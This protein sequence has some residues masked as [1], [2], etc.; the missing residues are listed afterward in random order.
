MALNNAIQFRHSVAELTPSETNTLMTKLCN[1][2][3]DVVL[4][5]IFDYLTKPSR[6]ADAAYVEASISSIIEAR[7]DSFEPLEVDVLSNSCIDINL[8]KSPAHSERKEIHILCNDEAQLDRIPRSL[9][10]VVSS[11]LNQADYT[12]LAQTSRSVYL[13]CTSPITLRALDWMMAQ[14]NGLVS[15]MHF[16][17]FQHVEN[18]SISM[19]DPM[20]INSS[21]TR[22]RLWSRLRMIGLHDGD[23]DDDDD[24]YDDDFES[25][26]NLFS[27]DLDQ[28]DTLLWR[29]VLD[30]THFK[31]MLTLFRSVL[32]LKLSNVQ[33]EIS[34]DELRRHSH[35]CSKLMGLDVSDS[36][37]RTHHA[38][39]RVFSSQL[40]FLRF[41]C[42]LADAFSGRIDGINFDQSMGFQNLEEV[43]LISPTKSILFEILKTA[44][45]LRK[46][47]LG[48]D[49]TTVDDKQIKTWI[50]KL[51][52]TCASLQYICIELIIVQ[53]VQVS[54]NFRFQ[55]SDV[56]QGLAQ[57]VLETKQLKRKQMKVCLRL[58]CTDTFDQDQFVADMSHVN[59]LLASAEIGD[60]MFLCNLYGCKS[61]P[62][63]D[64]VV[65]ELQ[66][67][68]SAIQVRR[69]GLKLVITNIGC[70]INGYAEQWLMPIELCHTWDDMM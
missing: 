26:L 65:A 21:A 61:K 6:S 16:N 45:V 68:L 67:A 31:K 8:E 11:F 2:R 27:F 7:P 15:S 51:F 10:G 54:E 59:L 25:L 13:G 47:R 63:L 37:R 50:V 42:Y 70:K 48:F 66:K 4:T 56:L 14:S 29:T 17:Y 52:R 1:E 41:N 12:K 33:A 64:P 9:I 3:S 39:L 69:D 32:Y 34:E 28:I 24:D 5:A 58:P 53:G 49:I 20:P 57:G 22:M 30:A 40:R 35:L 62:D 46:V 19:C 36:P 23:Y 18:L 38:F 43:V 44:V 55:L 60:F